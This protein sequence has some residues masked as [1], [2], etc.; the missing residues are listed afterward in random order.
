M[1]KTVVL[2]TFRPK[3]CLHGISYHVVPSNE[4]RVIVGTKLTARVQ[5]AVED[6]P[7][8]LRQKTMAECG[9]E[10]QQTLQRHCQTID[11]KFELT[12]Q[13]KAAVLNMIH[14]R[15]L[16][17]FDLEDPASLPP[18]VIDLVPG[19]EPTKIRRSYN[20]SPQQRE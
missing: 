12:D 13:S 11:E 15:Y 4:M 16:A 2:D 20:W 6:G 18:M 3:V 14:T 17:K 1:D 9:A 19:A 8:P 5:T 10:I 7:V